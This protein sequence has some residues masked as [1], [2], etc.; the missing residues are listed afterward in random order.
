MRWVLHL[1]LVIDRFNLN[2][3]A[4]VSAVD[5]ALGCKQGSFYHLFYITINRK[6]IWKE[7]ATPQAPHCL[8]WS[9][10]HSPPKLTLPVTDPTPTSSLNP[11]DLSKC[12]YIR[13]AV[14]LQCTGQTDRHTDRLTDG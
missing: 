1:N 13:S 14:L 11:F 10:P 6:S 9:A 2:T 3:T 4:H 8:Q 12:I 5:L 7:A